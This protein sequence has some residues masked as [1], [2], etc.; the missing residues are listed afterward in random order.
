M[1]QG[2]SGYGEVEG[3]SGSHQAAGEI[4][5][6][7]NGECEHGGDGVTCPPCV[8]K[9]RGTVVPEPLKVSYHFVAMHDGQCAGCD[10]PIHKGDWVARWNDDTVKHY[11]C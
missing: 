10:L 9:R 4:D 7:E 6:D 2:G 1:Q 5:L 11:E 3:G 8:N